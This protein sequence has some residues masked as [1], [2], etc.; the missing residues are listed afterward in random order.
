VLWTPCSGVEWGVCSSRHQ[1]LEKRTAGKQSA[2]LA[3]EGTEESLSILPDYT[4]TLRPRPSAVDH[5]DRD[6]LNPTSDLLSHCHRR[7]SG[8][9]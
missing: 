1:G 2:N 8:V 9:H 3:V 6:M 5:V 7:V 4:P